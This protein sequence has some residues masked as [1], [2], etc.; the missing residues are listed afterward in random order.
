MTVLVQISDTHFG[1]EQPPVVEALVRWVQ[2]Q[3]PDVLLL[4]GDVTQRATRSQF[5]AARAFLDRLAVPRTLVIPGNH[6][7]PLYALAARLF[8]PYGRF[9]EAFGPELEPVLDQPDCLLLALNTTRWW[10]HEDGELS[11]AQIEGVA[12]RLR[13]ARPGQLRIVAVHQPLV[14]TRREDERNLLHGHARAAAR[15]A[16]AGVDLVLGGHIHLPFAKPLPTRSTAWAVQAGTAVSSRVR[17]GAPNS[18]NL[19]RG[20]LVD[21]HGLRHCT[22][23]RW[24]CP[25]DGSAFQ[26]AEVRTLALQP[27]G[28]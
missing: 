28:R 23:E 2:A 16:K 26:A 27:L 5:A 21:T 11:E 10:R 4:S 12:Q 6:D 3:A 24:D 25:A 20:P 7:I 22:L 1:T 15:W 14:V 8:S 9:S 13:A 18:V 17:S 19:I